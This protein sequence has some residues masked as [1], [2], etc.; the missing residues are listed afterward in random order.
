MNSTRRPG[1][2]WWPRRWGRHQAHKA[3]GQLVADDLGLQCVPIPVTHSAATPVF[4]LGPES[5]SGQRRSSPPEACL[6]REQIQVNSRDLT[7][8]DGNVVCAD[9]GKVVFPKGIEVEIGAKATV[10][11]HGVLRSRDSGG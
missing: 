11:K 1:L 7:V 3:A 5:R 9:C 4:C 8:V 2:P 6:E 10:S